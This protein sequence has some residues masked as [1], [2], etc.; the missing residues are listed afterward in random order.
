M[1]PLWISTLGKQFTS[2]RVDI[3]F[4]AIMEGLIALLIPAALGMYFITTRQHLIKQIE[5]YIKVST[6][7]N[8]KIN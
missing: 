2:K 7:N 5:K 1:M 3:P 6:G 4:M 8:E